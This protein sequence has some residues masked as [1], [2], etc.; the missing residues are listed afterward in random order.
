MKHRMTK[1]AREHLIL[2][3]DA[4]EDVGLLFHLRAPWLI[5]GLVIGGL[6]TFV[7][8]RFE[9]VLSE[10]VSLAFFIP[11]IVYMSDAV[12]TQ[13]ETIYVRNLTRKQ[14]K[15]TTYLFK[16]LALGLIIGLIAG[17]VLGAFAFIWLGSLE[18]A[19]TTG[20]A[21][22]TSI[23]SAAAIALIFPTVLH[24][25]FK[26]DPAVG[27]GPFTTALQDL[28]SILIYFAVATLIIF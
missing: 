12:G 23:I 11:I 21:M 6:I 1:R 20:V 25:A 8:S 2:A 19:L 17:V 7:V 27:A 26:I 22:A 5:V 18:V 9:N 24:G 10:Q 16:E 3:D 28:T 4:T 15:F 14:V 13:T